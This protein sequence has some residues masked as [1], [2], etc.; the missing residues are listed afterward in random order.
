MS[1]VGGNLEKKEIGLPIGVSGTHN[2]TEIDKVT[3]FL[4]LAQTDIDGSGK[5][6]YVEEGSWTSDVINL[7]DKFQDFDKVFTNNINNGSSSIAVL[8][9]VSDDGYNWS[10]WIA[11]A[12]DGAIQ[13]ETKQYIQVRIDIFAGFVT[14]H[15]VISNSDFENNEFVEKFND[16]KLKREYQYDMNLDSKWSD[17]GSLHS[18]KITRNEWLRIDSLEVSIDK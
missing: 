14:D 4:R 18:K 16:I 8:T 1:T 2:N 7:E 5:S 17:T 12:E 9:R 10:D 11:I 13:S 6:I 3:G 15:F